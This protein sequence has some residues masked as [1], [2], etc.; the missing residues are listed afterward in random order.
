MMGSGLTAAA[1]IA[2]KDLRQAARDRSFF[3]FG[4]LAPLGIMAVFTF[5]IGDAFSGTL[6]PV[7]RI[8]DE[9]GVVGDGIV[10]GLTEA[11]FENVGR[12]DSADEARRQV[13]DGDADAAIIFPAQLMTATADPGTGAETVVVVSPDADVS[14]QIAE[15]VA[16]STTA[17]FRTRRAIAAALVAADP[18]IDPASAVDAE[19]APVV[20]MVDERPGTRVLTDATYFSVTMASFF[21]FIVAQSA[22]ATIHRERRNETLARVLVAPIPRWSMIA[23]KALSAI[24][25]GVISFMVLWLA[26]TLLFGARWGPVPGVVVIAV[27]AMVAAVGLAALITTFTRTEDSANQLI[28]MVSTALAFLGG[29]FIP[30]S[31][32]G[33]MGV[34]SSLSPMRWIVEAVGEN[35]GVGTAVDV[36]RPAL[37]IV[38][39][40]LVPGALALVRGHRLLEGA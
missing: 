26:S 25:T 37:V 1:R 40:G 33:L 3:V 17:S 10:A 11:G 12:L 5:T 31:T 13:D 15:A 36:A 18:T 38:V 14:A 19:P 16:R 20:T 32:E 24:A 9:T 35:A 28:A 34:L 23:G 4:V 27:A 21:V 6:N 30:L 7:I 39:F 8:V 29:A 22:F 2:L